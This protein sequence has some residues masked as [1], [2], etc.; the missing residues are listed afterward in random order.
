MKILQV[1]FKNRN[2]HTLR[3]IVTLPDTEGKVPFVVHLHGFA[4]SCSGYKSMYTHL[5]RALAAQGIGS[6]R[7]DFYGN[8]ESDGEFEDMSFDGL[9]TDAQD[10]FAWAAEQPYVD[11]EKLFLSGQSM[12]GYIAAS[13]APVIQP[14]GLIL[15]C[16]GA[17]MWFGCA[18]RAD[19]VVQTGKDYTDMEGLCYK[20]AFNYEMAKHPDPFTEAKGYNGPVLLL[21]ADDDRLV[22]EGTCSRYAQVYT[23]PEVDTIAGGGHN[24]ATLSARAFSCD[25]FAAPTKSHPAG[26][27]DIGHTRFLLPT[28]HPAPS[29]H[30][31]IPHSLPSAAT[32]AQSALRTAA[33]SATPPADSGKP[34][35]VSPAAPAD[36]RPL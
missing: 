7:F 9:H 24:F 28:A 22:D 33:L 21:R 29:S 2:G 19:G 16:P 4:G 17:G 20:M 10:I 12:G 11:S 27:P 31:H 34:G 36:T 26:N 1:Q 18:Q 5:S 8:G 35:G 25:T 30:P 3:G 6:A 13:C 23:A 32:P 15:L 14:H